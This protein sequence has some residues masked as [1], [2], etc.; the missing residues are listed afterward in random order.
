MVG[1]ERR[2]VWSAAAVVLCVSLGAGAWWWAV[3]PQEG[4]LTSLAEGDAAPGTQQEHD[5]D[6]AGAGPRG[7]APFPVQDQASVE[8][9]GMLEGDPRIAVEQAV[10][11]AR[12]VSLSRASAGGLGQVLQDTGFHVYAFHP[13]MPAWPW[14][15]PTEV[16][17][18]I[19]PTSRDPVAL[20][21]PAV[22]GVEDWVFEV[23]DSP[24]HPLLVIFIGALPADERPSQGLMALLAVDSPFAGACA[25]LEPDATT[26][27]W[28]EA[29]LAPLGVAWEHVR[30]YALGLETSPNGQPRATVRAGAYR[31]SSS[32]PLVE[33][34]VP[35]PPAAA[36][37]PATP[38]QD[39]RQTGHAD[40]GPGA[41]AWVL[42]DVLGLDGG[43]GAEGPR[44]IPVEALEGG[45]SA[46]WRARTAPGSVP[47]MGAAQGVEGMYADGGMGP[48]GDLLRAGMPVD[49]T[50]GPDVFEPRDLRIVGLGVPGHVLA[51]LPDGSGWITRSVGTALLPSQPPYRV[52]L[53]ADGRWEHLWADER[54]VIRGLVF[55]PSQ[56]RLAV[57]EVDRRTG[58]MG[59]GWS[60]MEQRLALPLDAA[61]QVR[62]S[63]AESVPPGRF[64]EALRDPSWRMAPVWADLGY[65]L[66]EGAVLGPEGESRAFWLMD[67]EEGWVSELVGPR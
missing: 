1:M 16:Q 23:E 8:S 21:V 19:T 51:M 27:A 4:T 40:A 35:A 13:T 43:S 20:L 64:V 34:Q 39:P 12:D 38:V 11:G 30:G 63:G 52:G 5:S 15:L 57:V 10:T 55:A 48:D 41:D 46:V 54:G 42:G 47:F 28:H 67:L 33:G 36:T 45:W 24:G 32:I 65:V 3:H 49:L 18:S 29:C 2:W 9:L 6:D 59:E 26:E 14:G 37:G 60:P 17:V 58:L 7:E 53:P 22:P 66:W 25:A 61:G 50:I 31:A 62:V 56:G 44:G